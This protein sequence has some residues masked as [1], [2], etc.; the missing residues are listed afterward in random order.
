MCACV[1]PAK[2]LLAVQSA[3]TGGEGCGTELNHSRFSVTRFVEQ[4]LGV[5]QCD[6]S[7]KIWLIAIR[8]D[9]NET[10]RLVFV[11]VPTNFNGFY[12]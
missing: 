10:H 7:G 5:W 11:D 2:R 12:S 3:T 1:R 4:S 8:F 6:T 9:G